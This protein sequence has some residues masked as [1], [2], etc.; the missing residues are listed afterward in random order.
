[1]VIEAGHV[2]KAHRAYLLW[3]EACG[4]H[5]YICVELCMWA[6]F[7]AE[8]PET[9]LKNSTHN[10][11]ERLLSYQFSYFFSKERTIFGWNA[12]KNFQAIY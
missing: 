7:T 8:F 1:M 9:Y 10:C 2:R 6:G 5:L 4:T 3:Q 12:K 11:K